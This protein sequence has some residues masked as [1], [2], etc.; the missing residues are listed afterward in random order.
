MAVSADLRH[1]TQAWD[2]QLPM[3]PL[4]V[5]SVQASLFYS[6]IRGR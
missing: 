5:D 1:V 3:Y 2:C 4:F 6:I